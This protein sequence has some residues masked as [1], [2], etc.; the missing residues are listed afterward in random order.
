MATKYRIN[1]DGQL[2]IMNF[3]YAT[4]SLVYES[5]YYAK[6]TRVHVT[7]FDLSHLKTGPG[8]PVIDA[9]PDSNGNCRRH[10]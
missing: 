5:E 2:E 9:P 4:D 8:D 3:D 1:N 6:G 7:S 10:K